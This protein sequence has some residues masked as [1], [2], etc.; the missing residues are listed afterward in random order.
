MCGIAGII[1]ENTTE[2]F[3]DRLEKMAG[4]LSHRGPDGKKSWISES[5][6]A[7]LAHCR[8]SIIDLSDQAKQPMHYLGRYTIVHNGEIY[9]Y[10]ELKEELLKKGYSFQSQTDTEVIL[11]AYHAW[12]QDCLQ[13]FDGMFSFAIW[14]EQNKKLFAARDRLGEKPFYYCLDGESLIFGSEMKAIWAAG[15][16]RQPNLK[17]LFNFITIGYTDNPSQP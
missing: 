9:N 10:V 2:I 6:M 14:D 17:M 4:S 12:K 1:T 8:L 3:S 13:Q 15:I 16:E 11:A 7:S 5:K